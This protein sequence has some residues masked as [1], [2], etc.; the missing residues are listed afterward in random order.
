[1]YLATG[2]LNYSKR[3]HDTIH[4]KLFVAVLSGLG[5]NRRE[6]CLHSRTSTPDTV[7]HMLVA[8]EIPGQGGLDYL[9]TKSCFFS[10]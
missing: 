7:H 4:K 2:W 1:M 8:G 10:A 5:L 9:K 3:F 6:R